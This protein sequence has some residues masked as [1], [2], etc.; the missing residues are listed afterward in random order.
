M[1][2]H[3]IA[4]IG[5]GALI[6]NKEN[7]SVLL[8]KKNYG[9][10]KDKWTFPEGY[11]DQGESPS[12][13]IKRE[14]KEELNGDIEVNDLICVRYKKLEKE[15][16]IYFVFNC[17]LLNK[18]KL[19]ISDK[20]EIKDFKLFNIEQAK[21]NSEIYSLVKVILDKY[22]NNPDFN[23]KKTDFIPSEIKIDKN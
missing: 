15:T 12:E 13:A 22:K 18:E 6:I 8:S 19:K 5:V 7:N 14:V 17:L 21:D 23:F 3:L 16:T 20:K 4:K 2:N 10:I 11:I 1:S 9:P